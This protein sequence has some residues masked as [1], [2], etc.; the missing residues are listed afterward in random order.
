MFAPAALI[1][2]IWA[3]KRDRDEV[4]GQW[5][6]DREAVTSAAILYGAG[7]QYEAGEGNAGGGM[8]S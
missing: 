3:V 7:T 5:P 6:S 8:E 1:L 4:M 2:A